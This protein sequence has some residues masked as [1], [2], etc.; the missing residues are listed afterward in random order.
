MALSDVKAIEPLAS[1]QLAT[2][3]ASAVYT[4]P[5]SG[6]VITSFTFANTTG[7]DVTVT[8][9]RVLTG[10]PAD[11]NVLGYKDKEILAKGTLVLQGEWGLKQN[12]K[13][14]AISNT[15]TSVTLQI[16]GYQYTEI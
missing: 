14:Y 9:Y 1:A 11:S 15:G 16:D 12:Q 4:G 3:A 10:S 8:L 7:S 13:I 5:A 2:T 6:V